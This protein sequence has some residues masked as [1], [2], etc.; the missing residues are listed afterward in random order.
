MAAKKSADKK[1]VGVAKATPSSSKSHDANFYR[2]LLADT[3]GKDSVPDPLAV[4]Q[5]DVYPTGLPSLDRALGVGGWAKGRIHMIAGPQHSG[6]TA[7]ALLGVATIQRA[8]PDSICAIIDIEGAYSESL[9]EL[10]GVDVNPDRFIVI[11]PDTA[12][13]S[14]MAALSLMG[15]DSKD[16]GRTWQRV[17]PSIDALIYDSWAGS[18]TDEV[19]MATLARAGSV[20]WPKVSLEVTKSKVVFFLVNQIRLKPGVMFGNPEYDP[21]GE[22]VKHARST[23]LK[24]HAVGDKGKD[25]YGAQ[26]WHTL[27]L[28]VAK[29]KVAPPFKT[30]YAVLHYKNGFDQLADAYSLL[31]QKGVSMLETVGG[32]MHVFSYTPEGMKPVKIRAN[33]KDKFLD[34]L[35]FDPEAAEAFVLLASS[36]PEH[37]E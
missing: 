18:P 33:G 34:E 29:N 8:K 9:A 17:R 11:R 30:V 25:A 3:L 28:Y 21:G 20:W 22:A 32:N 12:E 23:F 6:K 4:T 31:E 26:I 24:V 27:K 5:V 2:R 7:L 15:L 1:A 13:A 35:R 37:G 19:G 36:A 16:K 10:V 14:C